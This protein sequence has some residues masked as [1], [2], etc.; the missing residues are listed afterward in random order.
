M[1]STTKEVEML[2]MIDFTLSAPP[3]HDDY[4]TM[5]SFV[6]M[7]LDTELMFSHRYF[8]MGDDAEYHVRIHTPTQKQQVECLNLIIAWQAATAQHG[9]S[10]RFNVPTVEVT[11]IA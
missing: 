4:E 10:F 5:L 3:H 1:N 2:G 6:D 7:V 8:G 11:T 9:T